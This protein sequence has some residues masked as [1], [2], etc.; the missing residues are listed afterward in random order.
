M[1]FICHSCVSIYKMLLSCRENHR[2]FFLLLPVN[3]FNHMT[4]LVLLKQFQCYCVIEVMW[5]DVESNVE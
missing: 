3:F 2:D 4:L 5:S 1:L